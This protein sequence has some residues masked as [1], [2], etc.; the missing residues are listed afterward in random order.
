M[1]LHGEVDPELCKS[2]MGAMAGWVR[3]GPTSPLHRNLL[4]SRGGRAADAVAL[5]AR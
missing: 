1:T 2:G 3:W 4:H 5:A